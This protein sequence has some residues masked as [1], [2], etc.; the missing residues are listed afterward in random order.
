MKTPPAGIIEFT[1][2]NRTMLVEGPAEYMLFDNFYKKIHGHKMEEDNIQVMDV[3]GLSFKRFL[4][5]AAITGAKVAVVTDNDNDYQKN[6]IDK[7]SDFA[8][9]E[10][11]NIF[12]ESDNSKRTFE[13]VLEDRNKQ[14]CEDLFG[15]TAVDYMLKNKTEA[16]YQLMNAPDIVV[17]DYI[18]RAIRWI[19]S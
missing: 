14:L 19:K 4:E 13:I 8:N 16:A 9:I 5:I 6:C 1:L 12:Y 3:R 15:N 18:E 7:Y 10:N 17:P 2:S 11:I